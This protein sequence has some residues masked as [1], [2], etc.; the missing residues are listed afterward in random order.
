MTDDVAALVLTNNFRQAQALSIAQ[1]HVAGA[2]GPSIGASFRGWRRISSEP[3]VGRAADRRGARRSRERAVVVDAT[4]TRGAAVVREDALEGMSDRLVGSRGPGHRDAVFDEFPRVDPQRYPPAVAQASPVSR[5]PRDG[6]RERRRASPRD[7]VGPPPLGLCRRRTR[8][9]RARV[10]RGGA[11]LRHPR[12]VPKRSKRWTDVDGDTRLDMLLQLTQLARRATRWLLRHRRNALEVSALT[13]HFAPPI[14]ELSQ[15]RLALMGVSGRA[16]PTNRCSAGPRRV[17]HPIAEACGN[18]AALVTTLP[19]IDAAERRR[20]AA[21]GG[22]V[23]ATLNAALSI[24]W[25]ADQ[26]ARRRRRACGRRWSAT[27][28]STT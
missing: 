23:F 15:T 18:A 3:S 5:D 2:A 14:A 24:D 19:V 11:L 9:D 12:S 7:F 13:Q 21:S 20:A 17:C 22:E 8:R 16:R 28:C 27:C 1:R 25:L 10:L 26:L 6:R 4:G